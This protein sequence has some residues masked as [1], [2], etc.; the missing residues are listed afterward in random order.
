[1]L[2]AS[3]ALFHRQIRAMAQQLVLR[4]LTHISA[5][6]IGHTGQAIAAL[7]VPH[8]ERFEDPVSFSDC[9][10]AT[11]DAAARLTQSLGG[12]VVGGAATGGFTRS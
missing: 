9:C 5:P 12:G 3:N 10:V 1:M 6:I 7:T 11:I 8:I 2:V 4:P